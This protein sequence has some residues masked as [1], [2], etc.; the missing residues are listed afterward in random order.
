MKKLLTF[1]LL[2]AP[3]F[4]LTP[5]MVHDYGI[6][7]NSGGKIGSVFHYQL[8]DPNGTLAGNKLICGI[9]FTGISSVTV[10]IA[11]DGSNSYTQ[12]IK[13]SNATT[14]YT[15]GI[16]MTAAATGTKALTVTL[17]T[18]E[19]NFHM[20][21]TQFAHVSMTLDKSFSAGNITGP[22]VAA[23]SQTTTNA[24]DLIYQFVV[25]GDGGNGLG[26]VNLTTNFENATGF[27][28]LSPNLELGNVGQWGVQASAAAIN[29]TLIVNQVTHDSFDTVAVAMVADTSGTLPSGMYVQMEGVFTINTSLGATSPHAEQIPC[30][31]GDLLVFEGTTDPAAFDLYHGNTNGTTGWT[32][33]DGNAYT[34]YLVSGHTASTGQIVSASNVVCPDTN[35]HTVQVAFT[36]GGSPDPV[37]WFVVKGA[38]ARDTS[39]ASAAAIGAGAGN[40]AGCTTGICWAIANQGTKATSASVC[41][42]DVNS[43]TGIQVTPSTAKGILFVAGYTGQGPTACVLGSSSGVLNTATWFP[44]EDD[45]CCGTLDSSSIYDMAVYS[46]TA[47]ITVQDNW[48]NNAAAAASAAG[49]IA[50]AFKAATSTQYNIGK[51]GKTSAK[52]KMAIQ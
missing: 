34:G 47:Q 40:S 16:W 12:E 18:A 32:D 49:Y 51:K 35:S 48:T 17:S 2:C 42:N 26:F 37:H 13:Q 19:F 41:S 20:R 6:G 30:S 21:C 5:V 23:G 28:L 38:G 24:G 45:A 52:G 11:D 7:T 33:T 27:N 39:L 3:A 43:N 50:V 8:P 46:S 36:D 14:G 9:S 29:P 25:N 1:I 15:S 31:T 44:T 4:G 10:S 22:N